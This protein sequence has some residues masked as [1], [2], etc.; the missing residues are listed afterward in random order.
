MHV[1]QYLKGSINVGLFY[2]AQNEFVLKG[3][4]DADWGSCISTAKSLSGYAMFLGNSLISWKT[5]KQK[6]TSKSTCE[7]EYRSMSYATSELIWLHGLLS[8]LHITVS[9]PV[10][11]CCDN[12]AAQYIAEN[13]VYQE[14]TK[15]LRVDC[16]FIRDYV[17]NGFL[18]LIHVPSSLQLADVLTKALSASQVRFLCS[19]LGLVLNH[20]SSA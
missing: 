6:T 18:Q 19:K 7:A 15:H 9:L 17:D 20:P 4:C 12:T 16:H 13:Q 5:K 11:L 14:R 2:P 10:E 1:L 3:Y 8:D